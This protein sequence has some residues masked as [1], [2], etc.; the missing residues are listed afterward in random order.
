LIEYIPVSLKADLIVSALNTYLQIYSKA[1]KNSITEKPVAPN[2]T[3]SSI[4]F[5]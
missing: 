2:I 1:Q 4:A 5:L 3:A